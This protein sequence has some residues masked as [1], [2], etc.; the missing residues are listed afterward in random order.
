MTD[1]ECNDIVELKRIVSGY[2]ANVEQQI[3]EY[4]PHADKAIFDFMIL[5]ARRYQ[6]TLTEIDRQ[7]QNED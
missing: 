1:D 6:Q 7:L 5:K 3:L 4:S 2:L